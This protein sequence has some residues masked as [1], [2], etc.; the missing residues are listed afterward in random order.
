ML[1][2]SCIR[3]PVSRAAWEH[4]AA[5]WEHGAAAM[6]MGVGDGQGVHT[7]ISSPAYKS[8]LSWLSPPPHLHS[9]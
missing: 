7:T 3:W 5:A 8:M 9:P 4:G 6:S 1:V 2:D